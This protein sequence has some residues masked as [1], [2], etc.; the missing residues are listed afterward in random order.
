MLT[1]PLFWPLGPT[2]P[3]SSPTDPTIVAQPCDCRLS[4]FPETRVAQQLWIKGKS[5]SIQ[6][7]VL[8]DQSEWGAGMSLLER[9]QA[10]LPEGVT[11]GSF[12]G[13]G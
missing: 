9:E 4:V 3:V 6:R 7:L 11:L 5:F 13:G 8:G 1:S 2:R 12:E 10:V